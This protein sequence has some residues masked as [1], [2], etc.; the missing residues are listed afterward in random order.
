M[1]KDKKYF[2]KRHCVREYLLAKAIYNK[3]KAIFDNKYIP[4]IIDTYMLMANTK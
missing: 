3:D 4:R 2:Y 1:Q